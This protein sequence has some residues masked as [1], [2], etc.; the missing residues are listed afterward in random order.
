MSTIK[1]RASNFRV[2]QQLNWELDAGLYLLA[3]SNGTGKSTCLDMMLFLRTLLEWGHEAAF[4]T[5]GGASYFRRLGIAEIETVDFE[6]SVGKITWKLRFPM[7]NTGLKGIFAEELVIN[8]KTVL[9]A[10]LYKEVWQNNS[11]TLPL[12][13]KR[14]CTKVLLDKGGKEESRIKPLYLA[15]SNISIYKA[16]WLN[17][18]QN[19]DSTSSSVNYLHRTG[20]N[21]WSVLAA[22][23]NAPLRFGGQF[24]W[25]L[26][27]AKKAF[28]GLIETI[29]FERGQ[30]FI[31][32]PG[33]TDPADGLPPV[34]AADGLLTGLLQLTAVASA[35]KGT[36]VAFYE[37]ENQLHPHAI[38]SILSAMRQIAK[39][40]ELKIILTTHSPIVMNEFRDAP[41]H[42]FVMQSGEDSFP[43]PLTSLHDEDWLAAF[44][45]GDLYDRL[46]FAAPPLT[47]TAL[48][49]AEPSLTKG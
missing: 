22:W 45:L 29:E 46:D 47:S 26:S 5:L 8:G 43:V 11:L 6:V 40:R 33:F 44:S 7:S 36:I 16:F 9:K 32:P 25:V 18:V 38:R 30:A 42:F 21:L 13:E 17:Q 19:P 24:D 3:G 15:L 23:K 12:D 35:K 34:R 39:E 31:F 4:L 37:M 20:K 10:D 2:I 28:P 27:E 48:V 49:T 41:D 14:C 1:F